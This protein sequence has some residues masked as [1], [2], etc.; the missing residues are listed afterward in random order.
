[1]YDRVYQHIKKFAKSGDSYCKDLVSVLQQR[2]DLEKMYAKGLHRLANKVTKASKN[3]VKNSIFEGWNCIS[4]EMAFTADLHTTLASAIQQEAVKPICKMLDE[5]TKRRKSMDSA[6][7]KSS[8]LVID[9]WNQQIRCKKKVMGLTK[10]HEAVFRAVENN[11]QIISE[12]EKKKLLKKLKKSTEVLSKIDQ[13]YYDLNRAGEDVRLKWESVFEQSYQVIHDLEKEKIKLLCN[14]LNKYSQHITCF[15]RTL[16]ERQMQIHEVVQNV[17]IDQ[18]IQSL[19]D[20]TSILSD[21][22][23]IGFL[24]TDYY[25]EDSKNTMDKERRKTGL[26]LKLQR[27]QDDIS[28]VKKDKQGLEKMIRTSLRNPSFSDSKT[29]ETTASLRQEAALKLMLLEV[30]FYKLASSMAELEGNPKPSHPLSDSITNWKDKE[31][32]HSMVQ[33]SRPVKMKNIRHRSSLTN[34]VFLDHRSH[35][36]EPSPQQITEPIYANQTTN[37]NH[38]SKIQV[39]QSETDTGS[40]DY[41]SDPIQEVGSCKALY[42]YQAA[43]DDELNLQQGDILIIYK[44]DV[45]GWWLGSLRGKKGIFP[46][47]YVEELPQMEKSTSDV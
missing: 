2:A 18:D 12:K 16:I 46:A 28:K 32:Y 38:H 3:V 5:Q 26:S 45:T 8:K 37:S 22:N 21:E 23:K 13:Q 1:M 43:R 35:H 40:A 15:G 4:Q 34:S 27:L 47:T 30:N 10:D 33:I 39:E 7:E 9:N 6:V 44:K 29:E 20:D 14:I 25:E 31:Y 11:K 41:V 42:D 17:S 24:L 19:L 36:E